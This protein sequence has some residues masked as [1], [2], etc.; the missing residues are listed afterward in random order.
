V[1]S[2]RVADA[3]WLACVLE[4]TADKPGNVSPGRA[5][6]D[7]SYDDLLVSARLARPEIAR[8]GLRAVGATVLAIVRARRAAVAANT[9]LGIALLFA[10]L[11]R[12][13]LDEGLRGA[14]RDRLEATLQGLGVGDARDA[15]EAIRLAGAGGLGT[16]AEHDVASVPSIGL[17]EAMA[18]AAGHDRV[19]SEYA[20]GYA[21]VFEHALPALRRAL[22][23]GLDGLDATVELHLELL[24]QYPDTLIARR[25]GP[26]VARTVSAGA[27]EVLAAGGVRTA[28]GRAA[29]AAFDASLR[30]ARNRLNPGTTA[31]LVAAA[32]FAALLEGTPIPGAAELAARLHR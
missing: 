13:A 32:L 24:G 28:D 3:A 19:A 14:L 9:N 15:Y 21:V 26:D 27:R 31:D 11:A 10:P 30:G 4:A 1:D 5:F 7:M 6:A 22:R 12:A 17:R 23:D 8:A 16:R 29:M 2:E 18:A 20:T 25:G